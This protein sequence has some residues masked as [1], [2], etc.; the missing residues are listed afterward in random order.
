VDP[1][2]TRRQALAHVGVWTVVRLT[3]PRLPSTAC[4]GR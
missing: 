2:L 1:R 3:D 4:V